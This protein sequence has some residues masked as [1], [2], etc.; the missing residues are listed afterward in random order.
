MD[1]GYT[2]T[3]PCAYTSWVYVFCSGE[4]P[5][6]GFIYLTEK[7]ITSCKPLY[8]TGSGKLTSYEDIKLLAIGM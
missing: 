5:A 2:W 7:T 3:Y 4:G 6:T 8:H 1:T